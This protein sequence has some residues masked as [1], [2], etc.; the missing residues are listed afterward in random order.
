LDIAYSCVEPAS[1][2]PVAAAEHGS[3]P[4][5]LRYSWV[6]ARRVFP[7]LRNNANPALYTS[8]LL[9]CL[10]K[11]VLGEQLTGNSMAKAYSIPVHRI[12][13]S[14]PINFDQNTQPQ[15]AFAKSIVP[16]NPSSLKTCKMRSQTPM[17]H[18]SNVAY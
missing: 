12:L 17:L 2:A 8:T 13:A 5:L 14:L 1:C 11:R 3:A 15:F 18:Q 6:T 16:F 4:T 9:K 7:N 10:L